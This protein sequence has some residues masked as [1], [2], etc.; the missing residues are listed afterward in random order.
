[1]KKTTDKIVGMSNAPSMAETGPAARL[2][3]EEK[4]AA[5]P[6]TVGEDAEVMQQ[7]AT[8]TAEVRQVGAPA[9]IIQREETS[10]IEIRKEAATTETLQQRAAVTAAAWGWRG[11]MR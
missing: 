8:P 6:R 3:A 7:M 11:W 9:E 2:Q 1:M 5:A 10:L 4:Q